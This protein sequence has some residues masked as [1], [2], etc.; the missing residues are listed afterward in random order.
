M[1]LLATSMYS[2]AFNEVSALVTKT[3]PNA[4]ILYVDQVSNTILEEQYYFKKIEMERQRG[5]VKEEML[6]HGTS[7]KNV[8]S[9]ANNGFDPSRN[10]RSAFGKGTYLSTNCGYSKNYTDLDKEEVSYFFICKALVGRCVQGTPN[11]K[12]DTNQFDNAVD[13]VFNPSIYVVPYEEAVLPVYLV[14]FHKNA[15]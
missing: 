10:T 15:K 12:I 4:C 6:F 11:M 14:A 9:I 7:G 3:Y 2:K 8:D 5:A 1:S 13:N